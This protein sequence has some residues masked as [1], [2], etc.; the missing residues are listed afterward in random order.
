MEEMRNAYKVLARKSYGRRPLGRPRC[1]GK[2]ILER[3]SEK[4]SGKS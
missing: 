4:Q 2:I 1:N 3:I